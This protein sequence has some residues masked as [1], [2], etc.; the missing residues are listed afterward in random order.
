MKKAGLTILFALITVTAF[1][2]GN[3]PLDDLKGPIDRVIVIL[4]D[5]QYAAADQ[6]AAQRDKMWEIVR[7][8][9]DFQ[10][11]SKRTLAKNW[12]LFSKGQQDAFVDVYA[13]FLAHTYLDKIQGEYKGNEKVLYLEQEFFSDSKALIKTKIVRESGVEIPIDYRMLQASQG[14]RIYDV[15]IEGVSLVQNYR[16]QFNQILMKET[17][18]QLIERLKKKRGEQIKD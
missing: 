4:N 1:A 13:D 9:F 18:D 16:S 2:T 10:E 8:V 11:I 12:K 14:W 7:T 15:N 17:P 6:K 3:Q 5:P